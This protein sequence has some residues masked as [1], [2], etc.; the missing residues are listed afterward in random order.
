MNY[1]W[2]TPTDVA[3]R[4]ASRLKSIRKRKKIT[5]KELAGR[6]NVSYAT[7]RKFEKTGQISLES[8]I[9]LAMELGVIQELNSLFTEPVYTSIEEVINASK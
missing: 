3:M 7:L 1:L 4:L 5:Q 8:F 2:D 6:S 9:K